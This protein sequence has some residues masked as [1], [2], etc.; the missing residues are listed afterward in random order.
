M[1]PTRRD[2]P[3]DSRRSCHQVPVVHA[4]GRDDLQPT[5]FLSKPL[6]LLETLLRLI[7]NS[8]WRG[9]PQKMVRILL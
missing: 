1:Y 2:I 3:A 4:I 7:R 9:L 5:R 6:R 8:N